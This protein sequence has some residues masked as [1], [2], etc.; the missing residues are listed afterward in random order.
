VRRG[1]PELPDHRDLA[2]VVPL[3]DD[4]RH[5]G[6][7]AVGDGRQARE[8]R[9]GASICEFDGRE[10]RRAADTLYCDIVPHDHA[11]AG[12]RCVECRLQRAIAD[13]VPE[14]GKA[15]LFR[16]Q[17]HLPESARL[18][19]VDAR[20]RR[21]GVAHGRHYVPYAKPLEDQARA[22]RQRERAIAAQRLPGCTL[23][24]DDH[25]GVAGGERQRQ[26][27][28]D[29]PGADDDHIVKHGAKPGVTGA[30]AG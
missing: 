28:P 15:L 11:G 2:V 19:Y 29:G 10:G 22:V 24:E 16:D 1:S 12:E 13:D 6:A 7:G 18:R 27:C 5:R 21:C 20:N 17:R 26:C 8:H 9:L 4:P 30:G 25:I 14:C 23:V 3:A